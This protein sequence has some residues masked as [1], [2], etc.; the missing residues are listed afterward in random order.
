M[1]G[2]DA[3]GKGGALVQV[4]VGGETKPYQPELMNGI[5]FRR[6]GPEQ[7]AYPNAAD[8]PRE[9]PPSRKASSISRLPGRHTE[10]TGHAL[11]VAP[12]SAGT[13]RSSERSDGKGEVRKRASFLKGPRSQDK[14]TQTEGNPETVNPDQNPS[15]ARANS[16]FAPPEQVHWSVGPARHKLKDAAGDSGWPRERQAEHFWQLC[17]DHPRL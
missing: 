8:V 17:I 11:A 13:R 12:D 3:A 16:P 2:L 4:R 10:V 7:L 14:G 15:P 1:T 5:V 9:L 6:H